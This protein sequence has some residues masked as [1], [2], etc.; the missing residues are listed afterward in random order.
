L[1]LSKLR[2]NFGGGFEPPKPPSGYASGYAYQVLSSNIYILPLAF[3]CTGVSRTFAK[4]KSCQNILVVPSSPKIRQLSHP[5]HHLNQQLHH[6]C[7]PLV[8][9]NQES[10][11]DDDVPH[12]VSYLNLLTGSSTERVLK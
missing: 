7:H 4:I 11:F 9:T 6:K 1:A 12:F 8:Q 5:N 10:S 3:I 2:N